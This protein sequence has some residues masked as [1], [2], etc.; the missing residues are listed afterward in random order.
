[1][2]NAWARRRSTFYI[3][4]YTPP[5][6]RNGSANPRPDDKCVRRNKLDDPTRFA[7]SFGQGRT[8]LRLREATTYVSG[9]GKQTVTQTR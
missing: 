4:T 5:H 3:S 1:M 8:T 7:F 2:A 9:A 6:N